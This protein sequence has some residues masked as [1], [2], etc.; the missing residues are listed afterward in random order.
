[1]TRA[2]SALLSTVAIV[3]ALLVWL[4]FTEGG[5]V[6]PKVLVS[7][8][9]LLKLIQSA[10]P[11]ANRLGLC[12]RPAVYAVGLGPLRVDSAGYWSQA[13]PRCCSVAAVSR[14]IRETAE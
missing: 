12:W 3:L 8:I 4:A 14:G 7:P 5:L 10:Y 1:M 9:G 6:S 2:K 13:G 11:G